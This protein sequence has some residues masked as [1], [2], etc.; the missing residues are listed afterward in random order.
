MAQPRQHPRQDDEL[1]MP[2]AITPDPGSPTVGPLRIHRA[3]S[4]QS[5]SSSRAASAQND[6]DEYDDYQQPPRSKPPVQTQPPYPDDRPRVASRQDT[7]RREMSSAEQSRSQNMGAEANGRRAGTPQTRF[8]FGAD[9]PNRPSLSGHSHPQ[10]S[11]TSRPVDDSDRTPK[12]LPESPGPETPDKDEEGPAY[13]RTGRDASHSPTPYPEYEGP[14]RP[15]D[16][17]AS[18]LHV[19]DVNSVNRLASTASVS[20]TRA[21][22]GSPPPPETP[23]DKPGGNRWAAATPP[24]PATASIHS[25]GAAASQRASPYAQPTPKP[26]TPSPAR[27]YQQAPS[28][29]HQFYQPPLPAQRYQQSPSP[30]Q[31]QQQRQQTPP[32][33]SWSPPL[34]HSE[35]TQRP[36]EP[37]GNDDLPFGITQQPTPEMRQGAESAQPDQSQSVYQGHSILSGAEMQRLNLHEEPPPAYSTVPGQAQRTTP[38]VTGA[39]NYQ[40]DKRM[41]FVPQAYNGAQS[42]TPIPMQ[43]PNLAR[44]PAFALDQQQQQQSGQ[45]ISPSHPAAAGLA[46]IQI[47]TPQAQQSAAA[48]PSMN[49]PPP[50]PEGW[51]AHMD[52]NSGHY[53]YIHLPTQSTQ[54]EFPKG[55]TPLNMQEPMSPVGSIAPGMA[56]PAFSAFQKPMASP[57]FAPAGY[58]TQYAGYQRESMASMA[59]P[60]ATTFT[61]P[62]P[63]AGVDMYKVVPSNGVYF[64][65]YLR[66]TNVDLERSLWLGSI[67]LITDMPQPPTIHI[68][69]SVDLSPSPRQL[70]A[71]PI[72]SHQRWLFYR[73]DIDLIMEEQPTKWTYAITS[74]LGC[75]RYE[76]LIAGRY[77]T[78]WRFITHSNN[79]FALSVNANER[80]KLGGVNLMWKDVLQK[81][82]ECG[83]FHAQLGLGGQIYADRLWQDVPALRQWTT[84]S[85][86]ENRRNAPW[87]AKHE[88]DVIHAYFHYYTS[89]FDQPHLREAFAQIPH[90]LQLDD[91]DM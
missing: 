69:Q 47:G 25:Q 87:S 74:H 46:P 5:T 82:Q 85:G 26:A 33:T 75:T 51:I 27:P 68:H 3:H 89:H 2:G 6:Y 15:V 28:P 86:K 62:P 9:D 36:I 52:Q 72:Y 83:G 31:Q 4:P 76:F 88:E 34:G 44:H 17:T 30:A 55:P 48:G 59:S 42:T 70:K 50:L 45:S 18:Q 10:I 20:T 73:Y 56:S 65:P 24:P 71:N 1:F 60:T 37:Q 29:A 40:N 8:K 90:V 39:Q 91:H 66:Y 63:S 16:T 81:H 67:M 14:P 7:S 54:W 12:P 43:D 78:S 57:A 61:G 53:Y 22:R 49:S 84:M 64:G 32:Q 23:V 11:T 79:D 19:P 80:A 35:S 13:P 21:S 58:Q 38:S 41:S 77:E